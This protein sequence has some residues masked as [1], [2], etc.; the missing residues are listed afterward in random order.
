MAIRR[1]DLPA[2]NS[3]K[4]RRAEQPGLAD[5]TATENWLAAGVVLANDV[6]AEPEQIPQAQRGVLSM[7]IINPSR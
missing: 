7:A 1:G 2:A 3:A 5:P 6:I 4:I